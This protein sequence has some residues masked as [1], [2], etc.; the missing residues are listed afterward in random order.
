MQNTRFGELQLSQ[1]LQRAV[2]DMKFEEPTPIQSQSIPSSSR[3][4]HHRSG[5][6]RYGEDTSL[7]YP[8]A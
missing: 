6:N 1:E 5:S 7:W 2:D 4:G 3:E 8:H